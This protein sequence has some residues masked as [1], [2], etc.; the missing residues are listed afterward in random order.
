MEKSNHILDDRRYFL[1]LLGGG[2]LGST[3]MGAGIGGVEGKEAFQPLWNS[4]Q[5][6]VGNSPVDQSP[7]TFIQCP[8]FFDNG[9]FA[10]GFHTL[11]LSRA[12]AIVRGTV[13]YQK[14]FIEPTFASIAAAAAQGSDGNT[15]LLVGGE[16]TVTGG[17]GFFSNVTSAIIRCKYKVDQNNPFLLIAC[18]DCVIILS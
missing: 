5:V 9:H 14:D 1:K 2:V 3:S 10:N 6:F 15:Y 16:G 11:D 13:S 8:L 7:S 4:A 17:R 18:V 12:P